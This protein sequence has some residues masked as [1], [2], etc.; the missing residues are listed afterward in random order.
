MSAIWGRIDFNSNTCRVET[1]A[2][3]Y[4]RKCKLDRI[5]EIHYE[6]T[7]FGSGLQIINDEDEYEEMP[8]VLEEAKAV[9]TADVIL[10]NRKELIN[11]LGC[12]EDMI[13]DGKLICLAYKKWHYD[14]VKHLEGIFAI[15]IYNEA[16][17]ELFLAVDHSASRCLYYY[18]AAGSCTFS[19]L[20][21]PIVQ[22]NKEIKRNEEYLK[23]FL[24]LPGLVNTIKIYTPPYS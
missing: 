18:K 24:A 9:I 10:D 21:S 19:T 1:M 4:K 20:L 12:K 7:L 3:E 14:L 2:S 16:D 6:N 23:E 11:E 15:A 17:N 5:R 8:Y 13:P 22:T